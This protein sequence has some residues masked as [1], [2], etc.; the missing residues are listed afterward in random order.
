MAREQVL[1]GIILHRWTWGESDRMVSFLSET[2]GKL[3]LRVRGTQKP[4]SRMGMLT[5][6]LNLLRVRLI[7]GRNQPLL[8]QP[9]LIRTYF[10]VRADLERLTAALALCETL[11]RWLAE[12]YAE[13]EAYHT[14]VQ[15]LNALEIGRDVDSTVAWALW[16]WLA[17]LG[18]APDL[19]HCR[20]CGRPTQQGDWW[21][22]TGGCL[23]AICRPPQTGGAPS[24]TAEQIQLVRS[25]LT[26]QGCPLT[27]MPS[28][29]RLAQTALRYAEW[30]V[31]AEPRWL[32]FWE[33]LNTLRENG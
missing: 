25:W 27:S 2:R 18:Y 20:G 30:V 24:V 10:R 28:A 21:I 3:R 13:P 32:T 31:D 5:E 11:D 26:G 19:H 16:R 9:Q 17:L 29:G 22:Q 15:A 23:C 7:E 14:L 8:V 4:N 6:P 12:D 33:R 1:E